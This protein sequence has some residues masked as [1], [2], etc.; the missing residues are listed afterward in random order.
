M[1]FPSENEIQEILL[2]IDRKFK[3]IYCSIIFVGFITLLFSLASKSE[4]GSAFWGGYSKERLALI[5]LQI[6]LNTLLLIFFFYLSR[7][8]ET[9]LDFFWKV[10]VFFNNQSRYLPIRNSLFGIGLFLSFTSFYIAVLVPAFLALSMWL[11]Y[12]SW[13]VFAF[14]RKK[15]SQPNNLNSDSPEK[16][17]STRQKSILLTLLILG[18]AYFC[19]FIPI[20]LQ[21]SSS[22]QDLTGDEAV[23]YP[24]VIKMLESQPSLRLSFYQM[25][26]YG[27]Y[28]YG[29]PFYGFSALLLVPVKLIFGSNF[30]LHTQLNML[31][32]RQL[33]VVLPSISAAIIFTYLSTRFK[34]IWSSIGLFLIILTLPGMVLH[35]SLFWHPDALNLLFIALTIFLLD[36]DD[37]HF[38]K[39]FYL[40]A[41][42]CSLSVATR[43][44]G[45]FFFVTI[46]FLLGNAVHNK[47]FSMRKAVMVG[48]AFILILVATFM[49]ANPYVY[50]PG[51][52]GAAIK[53]FERQGAQISQGIQEP[54]PEGIYQ[55][56]FSAWW[57]F[58]NRYY[59]A[60]LTLA[61]LCLSLIVGVLSDMSKKKYYHIL[62]TWLLV[63][64]SYLIFFSKVKSY[65]YLL[66]LLIP[67]YS[68]GMAIPDQ[69]EELKEK[70]NI[71][72]KAK[73]AM[74]N[75]VY[76]I[77]C[78][79]GVLQLI[80][81]LQWIFEKHIIF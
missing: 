35:Q 6:F 2:K 65:W 46:L 15:N 9:G 49:V 34:K 42:T 41:V 36:R 27:E 18:I 54:D 33:V 81:N 63:V 76:I 4:P 37:L 80:I 1:I 64:G 16:Y 12:I 68:A 62:L 60:A 78:G 75:L 57:P 13:V 38:G 74:K 72:P 79:I 26:I 40:A 58:I 24:I 69:I 70:Y 67:L 20:N 32:L 44:F 45:L 59:G 39:D 43:M 5:G 66:P 8:K 17:F 23:Q 29:F 77:I 55:V 22:P 31:L 61:Y 30:S 52:L 53:I 11:T 56:G 21:F 10:N 28:E 50:K 14:F 51:E 19:I 3:Q 73:L 71:N 47:S 25:F 7:K 48:G